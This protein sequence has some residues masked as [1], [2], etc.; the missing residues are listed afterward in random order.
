MDLVLN[1]PRKANRLLKKL[2]KNALADFNTSLYN[3]LKYIIFKT[4]EDD[5][6]ANLLKDA[7]S[8]SDLKKAEFILK[9]NN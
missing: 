6:S 3:S 9:N 5:D 7:I 4:N 8:S 2:E 1:K